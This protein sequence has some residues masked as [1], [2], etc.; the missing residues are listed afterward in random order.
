MHRLYHSSSCYFPVS[1]LIV[2]V[3]RFSLPP[4]LIL[5]MLMFTNSCINVVIIRYGLAKVWCVQIDW[6]PNGASDIVSCLCACRFVISFFLPSIQLPRVL[7]VRAY[8]GKLNEPSVL[9]VDSYKRAFRPA[10]RVS[11]TILTRP[12]NSLFWRHS[13]RSDLPSGTW[14]QPARATRSEIVTLPI[15]SDWS[16]TA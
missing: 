10:N 6:T 14:W 9:D 15:N 4:L 8:D 7:S 1:A 11:G 16:P 5:A 13:N 12:L 3:F 2:R